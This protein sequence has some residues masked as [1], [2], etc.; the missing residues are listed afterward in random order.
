MPFYLFVDS[1]NSVSFDP[2]YDYTEEHE[3]IQDEHR[4]RSGASYIYKWG[5]FSRFSFNVRW[6]DSAFRS[7]INSWWGANTQL[8]LQRAGE[9]QVFSV[10]IVN[11]EL[12]VG[13]Y[14]RPYDDLWMAEIEL[15]TY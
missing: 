14:E 2:E 8:M 9:T 4:V 13:R 12:P 1:A 6:V 7:T 3:K 15:E 11:D 10:R 5:E